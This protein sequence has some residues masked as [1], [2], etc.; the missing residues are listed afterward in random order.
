MNIDSNIDG[1][2]T[3]FIEWVYATSGLV[4]TKGLRLSQVLGLNP[5]LIYLFIWGFTSLLT[6]YRPYHNG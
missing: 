1:K 4:F 6:L 5:V 2:S 3:F